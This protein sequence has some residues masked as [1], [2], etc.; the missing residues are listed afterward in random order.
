MVVAKRQPTQKGA[1]ELANID[2]GAINVGTILRD[3][4]RYSVPEFQRDFSWEAEQV[5]QLWD[6]F[7]AAIRNQRDD[8]FLGSFVINDKDQSNYKIID[9]QQR[10]TTTSI[11]VCVLRD[12]ASR[13]GEEDTA[14]QISTDF[15]GKFDY[16]SKSTIPKLTLNTNN[17]DF[18]DEN[19]INQSDIQRIRRQVNSRSIPKT[20]RL[21]ASCYCSLYDKV[22]ETLDG[23]QSLGD[24]VTAI[25]G[26]IDDTFQVIRIAVK[27]DHDAYLLFETLNDRGLALSVADLLKN[28]LFSKSGNKLQRTQDNWR[29]MVEYLGA[30]ELKRFLRH[31]WLSEYD[32]VREKYLYRRIADKFESQTQ[33]VQLSRRLRDSSEY[34]SALHDPEHVTWDLFEGSERSRIKANI[35]QLVTFNV[36]Q[37]N[38]LLLSV[39][40]ARPEIFGGVSSMVVAF[41]YRYSIIMGQGTGNI[42]K[43][44][45]SAAQFVRKNPS[46]SAKD[47]FDQIKSLYPSDADFRTSFARKQITVSK[48]ARYTL[49]KLNDH[50]EGNTG[51]EAVSDPNSLNLEHI[52]PQKFVP[53]EWSEFLDDPEAEI[54]EYMHRIG[55]MTLLPSGVNR[56]L[57]NKS[58]AEKVEGQY[59]LESPLK[60]NDT[61]AEH[62]VWSTSSID[63]R[64]AKL[65]R[66]AQAVWRVDY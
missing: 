10:L 43:V 51:I 15:L 47:V 40:E 62:E 45:A 20:N 66:I 8:Y 65:A 3:G 49:K 50:I 61:V 16:Q 6:D 11:L 27:D 42:E 23:G 19:I 18:Y 46:C 21:L 14:K 33:V 53:A 13:L 32:V 37:Y 34:Y 35:D 59:F 64:Q 48:L 57:A 39:I 30:I 22:G 60:I 28:Y 52:L 44:F 38:P 5:D 36:N 63:A 56:K 4:K 1:I 24:L 58:F 29:S 54:E 12:H 31:Y 41:A 17:R 55:N 25:T 7:L 2:T 26:A 9:G